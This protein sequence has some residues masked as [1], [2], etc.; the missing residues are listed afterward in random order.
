L[1]T[2]S[3]KRASRHG[4]GNH[5]ILIAAEHADV[6]RGLREIL[7][8]ALPEAR[9]SEAGNGDEVLKCLAGQEYAL[10]LLDI[11]MPQ[12]SGL[13]VLQNVKLSRPKMPVVVVSIQAEEPYTRY[14]LR[15]GAAFFITKNSASE[16]L[17]KVAK[18][19]VNSL[20]D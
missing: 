15:A 12:R 7:A 18:R 9:L 3:D 2:P 16:E 20:L 13:Q 14:F 19:L 11:D 10:L 8:D 6:R 5:D 17:P 1:D 4:A